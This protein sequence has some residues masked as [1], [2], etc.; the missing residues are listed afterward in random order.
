M[1]EP[2]KHLPPSE[3]A[4]CY[5]TARIVPNGNMRITLTPE[6]KEFMQELES[7]R[8][9]DSSLFFDL[10][11]DIIVNSEFDATSAEVVGGLTD[12]PVILAWCLDVDENENPVCGPDTIVWWFEAYQ[13]FNIKELLEIDSLL[14][15][16][17]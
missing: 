4:G 9:N 17:A 2:T 6:G 15:I 11:E 13:V 12:C 1:S 14:L 8:L 16:K 10:M 3:I 5:V 7:D